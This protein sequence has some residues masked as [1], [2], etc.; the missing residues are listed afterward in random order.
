MDDPGFHRTSFEECIHENHRGNK[1]DSHQ[2]AD[3]NTHKNP[4]GA[5]HDDERGQN[6]VKKIQK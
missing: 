2:E 3:V 5:G 6:L 1:T 4:G